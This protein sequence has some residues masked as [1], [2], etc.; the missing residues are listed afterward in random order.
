MLPA[1]I[2]DIRRN[3]ALEH[4]TVTI[5][6]NKL[7]HPIRMAGRASPDGFYIYG[8]VPT[9]LLTECAAEALLRFKK[10]EA[11]LA[12][13]PL[14][15]TNIAVGGVLC[16]F[17]AALAMGRRPTG[18][19]LP[20]AFTASAVGIVAAQPLGRW[21]QEHLTTQADLDQTAILGV[22][23]GWGGRIHKVQTTRNGNW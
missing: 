17:G 11:E 21:V 6:L 2:A 10:G 4:G 23:R 8:N 20:N 14:C 5:L 3:H 7:G 22:R 15:G 18:A 13:T 19:R 16:G 12:L 9:D 1:L